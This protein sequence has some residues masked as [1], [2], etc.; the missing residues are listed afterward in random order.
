VFAVRRQTTPERLAIVLF[1]LKASVTQ[2]WRSGPQPILRMQN[3]AP[4]R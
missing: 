2:G 1:D 3:A 4:P